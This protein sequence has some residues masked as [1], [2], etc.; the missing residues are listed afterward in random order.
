[1]ECKWQ[2]YSPVAARH[3]EVSIGDREKHTVCLELFSKENC[4]Q[5]KVVSKVKL[6]WEFV[7]GWVWDTSSWFTFSSAAMQP[8]L[9]GKGR[10][11]PTN[12]LD[13]TLCSL[14]VVVELIRMYRVFQ[15]RAW[16]LTSATTSCAAPE[17][18]TCSGHHVLWDRHGP[19]S[20]ALQ[21]P[22]WGS[23]HP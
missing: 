17:A 13:A 11:I 9:Y 4:Y 5:R 15:H 14:S 2:L 12:I 20:T 19:G 23:L 18:I 10:K 1:V 3:T 21:L 22:R 8:L 7:D 16:R 6:N